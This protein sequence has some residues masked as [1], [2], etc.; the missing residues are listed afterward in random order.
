MTSGTPDE[1]SPAE[2]QAGEDQSLSFIDDLNDNFDADPGEE[3]APPALAE[4]PA[5]PTPPPQLAQPVQQQ[6]PQV[7]APQVVPPST[8]APQA[9]AV[10]QPQVPASAQ[11]QPQAPVVGAPAAPPAQA[12][13][14]APQ[15]QQPAV[16]PTGQPAPQ[17]A[18]PGNELQ[19]LAAAMEAQRENF[20][21]KAAQSYVGSF[22]DEDVE[23]LAG[24]DP[25]AA[26]QTLAK[27]AARLHADIVQNVLGMMSQQVPV[28]VSRMQVVAQQHR[29]AEDDF[30]RQYPD[31]QPHDAAV[32][33]IAAGLRQANPGMTQEMF[34]PML[35]AMARQYAG[36]QAPVQQQQQQ[37][38]A[39]V[40]MAPPFQPAPARSSPRGGQPFNGQ[41]Q[42]Q[43]SVIDQIIEAEDRGVFE[44]R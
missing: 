14:P 43:W 2:Q 30:Y 11:Q 21:N 10:A 26:K 5:D 13:V 19:Q 12:Q 1:L 17:A 25:A 35:V 8:P 37:A 15:A 7:S 20:V 6:A 32:K 34:I 29:Q 28:M 23:A 38:P 9:P 27:M 4:P 22:S 18:A 36:S 33:Q 39:Q 24:A 16:Q 3:N 31:L 42:N 41:S 44:P 40:R